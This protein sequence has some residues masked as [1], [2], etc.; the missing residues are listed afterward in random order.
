MS[1]PDPPLSQDVK[2][3]RYMD[4]PK[5]LSLIHQKYL[6]F[7]KASS[8]EDSLEGMPT[9]LDSFLG[10]GAAEML[11]HVVN[12][13]WPS[14]VSDENKYQ[15]AQEKKLAAADA[16]ANFQERTVS[17]VLGH[18][19]A[20]DYP[21][22]L[23]I[24]TAVSNWVDVS[25]WHTDVSNAESMA[26]WKIYGGG[27][28]AVCVES[29]L[30]ALI[31][32]MTLPNDVVMHTGIVNYLDYQNACVGIDDPLRVYFQKS[33]F[34]E[35]EKELRIILYPAAHMDPRTLRPELGRK[36]AVAPKQLIQSVLVSPASSA[37]F[38]ELIELIL[39]EAGFDVLVSKSKIPFRRS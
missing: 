33:H 1:F 4:L 3:F 23:A 15:V 21:S 16:K 10:S 26:M 17:T 11:D 5:F 2:I 28:A 12:N 22:H 8:Y 36:I 14:P 25:C 24:F 31:G 35:F 38:H 37:W 32:A 30:G 7:A 9:N 20:E 6:F 19:R 27:S 39:K 34:Y 29:T 13:L 18:V